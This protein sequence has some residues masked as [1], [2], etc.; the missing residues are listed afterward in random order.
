MLEFYLDHLLF[1]YYNI[2]LYF[3]FPLLSLYFFYFNIN[4]TNLLMYKNLFYFKIPTDNHIYPNSTLWDKDIITFNC[5]LEKA[6]HSR[7]YLSESLTNTNKLFYENLTYFPEIVEKRMRY[8]YYFFNNNVKT[9]TW[10]E[11]RFLYKKEIILNKYFILNNT[12]INFEWYQ[13]K[14]FAPLVQTQEHLNTFI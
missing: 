9:S 5:L 8:I 11:E 14:G 3:T 13:F 12:K 6:L 1:L 4:N 10:W 7:F 2:G